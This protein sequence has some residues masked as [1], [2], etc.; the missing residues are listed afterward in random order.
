[1]LKYTC[2]EYCRIVRRQRP[3]YK[4][5]NWLFQRLGWKT[6]F[7]RT[8]QYKVLVRRTLVQH[9]VR[10]RSKIVRPCREVVEG[11]GCQFGSFR[12][13]SGY[14]EMLCHATWKYFTTF[15]SVSVQNLTENS[16]RNLTETCVTTTTYLKHTKL[17]F[18]TCHVSG[19]EDSAL[20]SAIQRYI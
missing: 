11:S 1:M 7:K 18:F 5:D 12:P 9:Y 6:L 13:P 17:E 20:L 2:I 10:E 8:F 14:S 16:Y 4:F 19:V 3:A 15:S